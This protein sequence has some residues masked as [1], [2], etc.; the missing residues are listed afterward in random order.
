VALHH[1]NAAKQWFDHLRAAIGY[2]KFIR[3]KVDHYT[4]SNQRRKLSQGIVKIML[5]QQNTE[6][7]IDDEDVFNQQ[8]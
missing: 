5:D 3:A 6:I 1:K 4:A 2:V 7:V 8:S